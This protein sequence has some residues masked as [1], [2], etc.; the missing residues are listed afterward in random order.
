MLRKNPN[1]IF[2]C[3][4]F[5]PK[6][7]YF[8]PQRAFS[9]ND[10]KN[11]QDSENKGTKSKKLSF[12]EYISKFN[13]YLEGKE[14]TISKWFTSINYQNMHFS[15]IK[16]FLLASTLF[17]IGYNLKCFLFQVQ[18]ICYNVIFFEKNS[19]LKNFLKDLFKSYVIQ[20]VISKIR[21]KKILDSSGYYYKADVILKSGE[22]KKME[23]GNIDYFLDNLEKTQLENNVPVS[24]LI[25]IEFQHRRTWVAWFEHY[26]NFIY[27]A[28]SLM[29][30]LGFIRNLS[31]NTNL[32][33]KGGNNIFGIGILRYFIFL[34][35]ICS[36][37]NQMRKF[38]VSKAK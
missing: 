22:Q 4:H 15:N 1:K 9:Q 14:S 5:F 26:Y 24:K 32:T 2:N 29:V 35:K 12:G 17:F 33:N 25:P 27:G 30:I 7:L 36:K 34:Q 37:G 16:L 20:N 13:A 6:P 11:N 3:F 10:D 21:I 8:S 31:R 23:I 19:F 38:L 28:V 18:D